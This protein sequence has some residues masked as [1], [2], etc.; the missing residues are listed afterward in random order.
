MR[1][2]SI[3]VYIRSAA[4][5]HRNRQRSSSRSGR[6]C[7]SDGKG[8][9][10]GTNGEEAASLDTSMLENFGMVAIQTKIA[11]TAGRRDSKALAL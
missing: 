3:A 5:Q 11:W 1:R 4:A 9:L 10:V 7:R 2:F 8:I 6:N